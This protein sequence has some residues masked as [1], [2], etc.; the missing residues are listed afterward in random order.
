[1]NKFKNFLVTTFIGGLVVLLPLGIF[2][3]LAKWVF[4]LIGEIINPIEALFPERW[5]EILLKI[6]SIGIVIAICFTFGLFV[7]TQFGHTFFTWFEENTLHKLPF[8]S[9]I[10]ETVQQFIGKEKTP[11]SKVVLIDPFG[12]GAKMLGFVTDETEDT[13]V[14]FSPTAPNPTN[15]YVFVLKHD[16]VELLDVKT[17]AAMKGIIS[18]G[19]GTLKYIPNKFV[20][21]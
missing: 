19:A 6:I 2:Y 10:K 21:K 14:V 18:L 16:Q 17:E 3:L 5:N 20:S 15:G 11:F 4:G 12:N 1:M 13:Y 9:T 8:Y 7:K